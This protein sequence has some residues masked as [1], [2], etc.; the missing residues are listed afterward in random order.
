M[1]LDTTRG[2]HVNTGV[3]DTWNTGTRWAAYKKT[4]NIKTAEF[5]APKNS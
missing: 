4:I 2:H 3:G 5:L 1:P